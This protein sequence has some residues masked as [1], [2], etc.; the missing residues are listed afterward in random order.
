MQG[1]DGQVLIDTKI[2]TNGVKVGVSDIQNSI[3]GLA[4]VTKDMTVQQW[5]ENYVKGLETVSGSNNEFK[6][7]LD[8]LSKKLKEMQEKGIYFGDEEYDR[9]YLRFQKVTQALRDYKKE[10]TSPTQNARIFDESTMEGQIEKLKS[11]LQRLRSKGKT[12]GDEEYDRTAQA[13]RT[14]EQALADYRREL[15]KTEEQIQR[16]QEQQARMNQRLEETRQKEAAAAAEAQRLKEIGES[17]KIS[18]PKIVQLS[19]ELEYLKARQADLEK[20]GVSTGY[21]EYERNAA[22]I[23]EITQETD[24]Y[25]NTVMRF[26]QILYGPGNVFSKLSSVLKELKTQVKG[27]DSAQKKANQSGKKFNKSIKDTHKTAKTSNKNLLSYLKTILKYTI[28]IRSTYILFNRIRSGLVEGMKNLAKYS[29]D[30]NTALSRLMS[31]MTRLK[32]SFAT[33]FAPLVQFVEPALTRFINLLSS[34]LTYIGKLFAALSGKEYFDQA[35]EVQQDF[36]ESLDKTKDSAK[37]TQ[38]QLAAFDELNVLDF[39]EEDAENQSEGLKPEDMF[40]TVK[41]E[42]NIISLAEKIK[43]ILS[44]L[45]APLKQ[46][47]QENGPYVIES[48]K[49]AAESLKKL[50]SDMGASFMQVWN[51]EGYGKAITDDLLI[52]LGNLFQIVGNLATQFDKA[53]VSGETG[54]N[55]LRHLGDIILEITDFFRAASESIMNWSKTIDFSP[56]L[57]A[58][59]G[60]LV[61]VRPIVNDVGSA[62]LWLLDNVLLPLAK[63]GIE[64]ALPAVFNVISAALKALHSV[65]QALKPFALWLWENFLQ[66]IGKWTG[67]VIIAALQKLVEWLTKFSD[68]ITNHQEAVKYI[69][70]LVVSF[71][72][73]WKITQFVA[74]IS[75]MITAI[76][77]LSSILGALGISLSGIMAK[78][79][80]AAVKFGALTLAITGILAVISI[81]A[82]NWDKMTPGERVISGILAAAAAVAVLAVALA[83]IKGA[84]GVALISAALVAGIAAA[85]IAINA[86]KRQVSSYQASA[87]SGRTAYPTS[88][89]AAI[90]YRMPRLAT[91]T[92]VPPRA[93]EFA[94]ILGDN[95]REP[96]VVSPLSTMR[97]AFREEI[98][99]VGLGQE[100][101]G[102]PIYMQIDGKTFARLM[103]PYLDSEKSRVGVNLVIG[104]TG[105]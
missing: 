3:K 99:S 12:F 9:T 28:G 64:Q 30:T 11:D 22:R 72:A 101:S 4:S 26:Y 51:A 84:V 57:K 70:I 73:A 23:R 32:N 27:V 78:L 42:Q 8:M 81:L 2:N 21:E 59:D 24:K 41:I 50:A 83:G 93:G 6:R 89:Y 45:F 96:E 1:A 14:A 100:R 10:L 90:P 44:G 47:W 31:A 98:A 79:A 40:E 18:S 82:M 5:V 66:P 88:A 105:R 29:D 60:I 87:R 25:R 77:T 54:T 94:A 61:A 13:L 102:G 69:T 67:Q 49:Y 74:G 37:K 58:F 15:F 19:Q 85:T 33:A 39:S 20:A 56:L 17:A 62:L 52:T 104:G 55:I 92:V 65:I 36:R 103:A 75:A 86:G 91:G 38:K 68:W 34:G 80:L 35:K 48:M 95:K 53:W 43:G 16:E 76:T 97:Q 63:W 71:F 7:E 46:S